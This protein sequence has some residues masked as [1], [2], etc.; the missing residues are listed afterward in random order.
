MATAR[1]GWN[2]GFALFKALEARGITTH[3]V[4]PSASYAM[5]EGKNHLPVILDFSTFRP[6][7]KDMIDACV[8]AFTVA[9]FENGRGCEVGSDGLGTIVIPRPLPNS[10]SAKLLQWPG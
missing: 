1:N 4:F 2:W 5:L 3:E 10:V 8:A 6:G 9:E 7:A